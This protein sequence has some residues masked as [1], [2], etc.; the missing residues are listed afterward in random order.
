MAQS[1]RSASD[2]SANVYRERMRRERQPQWVLLNGAVYYRTNLEPCGNEPTVS[3]TSDEK[4]R[5]HGT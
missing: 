5:S 3:L 4:E 1:D 2:R